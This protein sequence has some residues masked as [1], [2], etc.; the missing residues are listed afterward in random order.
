MSSFAMSMV[1]SLDRN[2]NLET[3]VGWFLFYFIFLKLFILKKIKKIQEMRDIIEQDPSAKQ[4]TVRYL[5]YDCAVCEDG[6]SYS[7]VH[8]ESYE[9]LEE[10]AFKADDRYPEHTRINP[11]DTVAVRNAKS[12]ADKWGAAI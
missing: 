2:A 4:L 1:E 11:R 12:S 5:F 8:E 6:F 3:L 9:T 7:G 10:F